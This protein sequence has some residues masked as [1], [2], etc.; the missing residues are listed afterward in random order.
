M[1]DDQHRCPSDEVARLRSVVEEGKQALF[2][3]LGGT[4]RQAATKVRNFILNSA[5]NGTESELENLWICQEHLKV[6]SQMEAFE[7]WR[8]L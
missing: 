6:N 7:C 3:K 1:S 5:G 8:W 4:K 2:V